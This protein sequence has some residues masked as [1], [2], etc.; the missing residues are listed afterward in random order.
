MP[1]DVHIKQFEPE[2]QDALLKFLRLAYPG[3]PRKSE[4]A[5]WRWHFL[6][7]PLIKLNDA[8]LWVVKSGAQIVG[9]L[10]AIPIKLKVGAESIRSIWIIDL[11]VHQ[12]YRGQKL[13]QRL[14]ATAFEAYPTIVALGINENSFPIL[15]SFNW[16]ELGYIHRYHRL[17]FPGDAVKELAKLGLVRKLVN[18]VY[19]PLRPRLPSKL[20]F[21]SGREVREVAEFDSSFDEFWQRASVNWPC[22]VERSARHL[23]WQF[24][25]QPG[26]KYDVL[27][28][29][30]ADR[31]A[32]YVV[33]FFRKPEP[34]GSAPPKVAISDFC[35]DASASVEVIDELLQAALH[36][37]LERR[38]GSLVIDILDSLVEER[39]K[40]FGFWRI[41][42]APRFMA[43]TR[44][45]QELIYNPD[46]WFIT[47][48]DSDV[49]IFE[50]PNV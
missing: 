37:A 13:G 6:E 7:H 2:E 44:A 10:A 30:E 19:A 9:Q 32:G 50:E 49:S 42:N 11:I 46:N 35:Y 20:S 25:R 29:Y 17:L 43:G 3:E 47:R 28:L 48:G 1:G 33:L 38:A 15:K 41:K 8:P 24:M 21:T 27:G 40:R 31:L 18:L 34:R 22:A 26:K 45:R 4:E 14:I 16:A 23:D 39:L 12:D 5:F 36:L